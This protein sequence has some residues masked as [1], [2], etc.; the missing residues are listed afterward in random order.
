[1]DDRIPAWADEGWS[2]DLPVLRARGEGQDL[3]YMEAFPQNT[4]ELAKEIAAFAASNSG[5]VPL[6]SA[7]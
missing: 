2:Q 1:M 7:M 5:S 4:R 6:P 3:E